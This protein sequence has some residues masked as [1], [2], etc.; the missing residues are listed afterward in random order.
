MNEL[1]LQN[2]VDRFPAWLTC[3]YSESSSYGSLRS[4]PPN[5]GDEP[6]NRQGTVFFLLNVECDKFVL[7]RRSASPFMNP[8][9][10]PGG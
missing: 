4:C 5:K 2:L 6:K 1:V 3:N 8:F 9:F 10:T 7:R